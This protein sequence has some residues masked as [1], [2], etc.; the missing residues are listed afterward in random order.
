MLLVGDLREEGYEVI[1]EA[2]EP[3]EQAVRSHRPDV[4]VLMIG[5]DSASIVCELVR[6]LRRRSDVPVLLIDHG[7]C[8]A[9]RVAGLKA[10]ADD[11][12]QKPSPRETLRYV[13]LLLRRAGRVS[14][15]VS[16]V[17]DLIVDHEAR[18]ALRGG[19]PLLLTKTEFELLE[20]FVCNP[21][22]TLSKRQLFRHAWGTG[23]F[24][25]HLVEVHVSA[26][27][28]KL[29]RSGPRMIDTVEGGYALAAV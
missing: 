16:Q 15:P 21:G 9:A 1:L 24:N 20:L 10:G 22:T 13:Q 4:I 26:M 3:E 5:V 7:G 19:L 25:R 23:D 29:E 6:Q 28:R 12:L 8:V 18:A 2:G 11:A 27:R 14:S 17:G